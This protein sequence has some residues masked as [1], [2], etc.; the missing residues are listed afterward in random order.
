MLAEAADEYFHLTP[1]E[2][3]LTYATVLPAVRQGVVPITCCDEGTGSVAE[4]DGPQPLAHLL[5]V[6]CRRREVLDN[7]AMMF[8]ARAL[9]GAFGALLAPAALSLLA[10]MF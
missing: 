4:D 9:Q 1:V 10:V 5:M 7:E 8:G 6:G 2:E 3:A